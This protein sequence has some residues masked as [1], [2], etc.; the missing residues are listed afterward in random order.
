M[1]LIR[2][3]MMCCLWLVAVAGAIPA[4]V[5]AGLVVFA[6]LA[7]NLPITD[8]HIVF[9]LALVELGEQQF[10][11]LELQAAIQHMLASLFMAAVSVAIQRGLKA[12]LSN[13]RK[14][15]QA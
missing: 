12:N 2:I 13:G 5:A 8:Q 6:T 1:A 9:L 11:L 4:L 10:R 15:R 3:P 14:L 7:I